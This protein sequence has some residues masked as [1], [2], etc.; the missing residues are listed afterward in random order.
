MKINPAD[1]DRIGRHELFMSAVLPRP[2]A[3]VSTVGENGVRNVAPFSCFTCMSLKP[4]T[5]CIMIGYK[6]D[7]SR[8]DTLI[9]VDFLKDF[10]IAVVDENMAQPM[11]QTG[12]EYPPDVDEFE[13]TGL[14]P[15]KSDMVNSFRVGESAINMECKLSRIIKFGEPPSGS[16]LILGE[17]VLVHVKDEVW[18]GDHIDNSKL[19][20]IGRLGE[21][22]YCRTTDMF[23]MKRAVVDA[24]QQDLY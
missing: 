24:T 17:V 15:V 8:K 12:G 1:M 6:R 10:V 13:V 19:K 18:R 21:D 20:A 16:E 22:L 4:A 5:V 14:T 7:G 11:N 23:E 3:L 2:I 9:N